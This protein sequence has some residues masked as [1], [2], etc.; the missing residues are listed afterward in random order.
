M[1]GIGDPLAQHIGVE[2]MRQGHRGEGYA[3]PHALG[4]HRRLE[5]RAVTAASP[6]SHQVAPVNVHVSAKSYADTRLL[7]LADWVNMTFLATYLA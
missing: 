2:A 7:S 1:L 5:L 6:P 3:W 4:D